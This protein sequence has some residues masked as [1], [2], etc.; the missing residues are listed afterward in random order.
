MTQSESG[1]F[2]PR[3][4]TPL[5]IPPTSR[6]PQAL[7]VGLRSAEGWTKAG[8]TQHSALDNGC[9]H[10]V[11][12]SVTIYNAPHPPQQRRPWSSRA[13]PLAGSR[14]ASP[15][16]P[17]HTGRL[18]I[19]P[20]ILCAFHT[21]SFTFRASSQ[22]AATLDSGVPCMTPCPKFNTNGAPFAFPAQS[23]TAC[24]ICSSVPLCRMRGSTLPLTP[25]SSPSIARA[26]AMSH[27]QSRQ[28]MSAAMSPCRSRNPLPPL[29]K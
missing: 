7:E 27:F 14:Q 8:A 20:E 25:R 2:Q 5:P 18:G 9:D 4:T 15:R 29:A 26:T 3:L 24:R 6:R 1:V 13:G 28:I 19:E 22:K 10:N 12:V 11:R 17:T 23:R 16:H 21:Q